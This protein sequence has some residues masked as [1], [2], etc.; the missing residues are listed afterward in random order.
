M[1]VKVIAIS[2]R[3]GHGKDT[4][5]SIIE[6]YLKQDGKTVLITHYADL[7]KYICKTFFG[8][9]GK[10]DEKGRSLLQYVGTDV[11]RKSEPNFWVDFVADII[12]YFEKQWDYVLIPDTRFPNEFD[13]LKEKSLDVIHVRVIR[14][15]YQGMLTDEQKKHP[16]ETAL[17]DAIPD[18]LFENSGSIDELKQK[19][20][21]WITEELYE[22]RR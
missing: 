5:A 12:K 17:D 6:D 16:S 9:D 4:V 15:N 19:I 7:L 20:K 10:K 11:I 18:Y 13:R 14:K 1:S 22:Q 21:T 8:W 2:G 3:A